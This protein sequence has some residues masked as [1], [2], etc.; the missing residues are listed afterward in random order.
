MGEEL[1]HVAVVGLDLGAG[2]ARAVVFAM[3]VRMK[4]A[5][6]LGDPPRRDIDGGDE[7]Q[8]VGE[9]P[10]D[11]RFAATLFPRRVPRE[12]ASADAGGTRPARRRGGALF[13]I[14]RHP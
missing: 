1:V 7:R 6:H 13:Q 5:A 2:Q 9:C 11:S 3:G 8:D 4:T 12:N 10:G 14:L